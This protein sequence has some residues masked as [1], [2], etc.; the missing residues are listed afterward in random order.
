[1]SGEVT[2]NPAASRFELASGTDIAFV[3]Y[4]REGSGYIV[5]THTEVPKALSGQG[6]GSRLV[7]GTLD[8]LRHEGLRVVPRCEF[9]AEFIE[10]HPEYR[11]L[12]ADHG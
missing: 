3:A 9:V 1:M 8:R 6:I 7:R 10:R 5:L 4:R 2:D 12:I 11:N